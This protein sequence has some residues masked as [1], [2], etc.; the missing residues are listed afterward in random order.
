MDFKSRSILPDYGEVASPQ[1]DLF[2]NKQNT[3]TPLFFSLNREK[4]TIG[5]NALAQPWDFHLCYAFS[6][7]SLDPATAKENSESKELQSSS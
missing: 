6:L 7:L 5:I 2:A 1:M 4:R 3:K